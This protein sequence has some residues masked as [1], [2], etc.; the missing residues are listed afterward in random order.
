MG[1][2]LSIL[3]SFFQGNSGLQDLNPILTENNSAEQQ[4]VDEGLLSNENENPVYYI[5][6]GVSRPLNELTE[7]EQITIARKIEF[8]EQMP[9]Y[10]LGMDDSDKIL[11]C[12]I[13]MEEIDIGETIRYLPCAHLF[14]KNCVDTWL[15][16]N[17]SCP[18]CLE[19]LTEIKD[20][21]SNMQ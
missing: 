11:E 16:R 12:I 21:L 4:Q 20:Y 6:P 10:T 7:E 14:H 3:R 9:S 2:C 15:M 8:L 19:E 18:T 5:S 13:C 17:L 1:C